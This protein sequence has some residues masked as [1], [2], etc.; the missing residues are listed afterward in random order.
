MSADCLRYCNPP[1]D[2]DKRCV[3]R[4]PTTKNTQIHISAT[5][6]TRNFRY[7][8]AVMIQRVCLCHRMSITNLLQN[9]TKHLTVLRERNTSLYAAAG[10]SQ[11]NWTASGRRLANGANM[12]GI[13]SVQI[14]QSA[15]ARTRHNEPTQP[16]GGGC[17][18]ECVCYTQYKLY[19]RE[20]AEILGVGVGETSRRGAMQ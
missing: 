9:P 5:F 19:L 11:Q 17:Q 6:P 15:H 16:G 12:K 8:T 1:M 14:S 7:S 10:R 4:K 2:Y 18:P 3:L 13:N 20:T